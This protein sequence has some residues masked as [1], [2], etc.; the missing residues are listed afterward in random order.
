M[1]SCDNDVSMCWNDVEACTVA[2]CS[3][4]GSSCSTWSAAHKLM[5]E[6]KRKRKSQNKHGDGRSH[7]SNRDQI[8]DERIVPDIS[9]SF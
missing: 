1:T 3:M 9:F 6:F 2:G 5:Y 7:S 4:A 8:R